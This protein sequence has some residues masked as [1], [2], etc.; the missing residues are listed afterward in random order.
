MKKYSFIARCVVFVYTFLYIGFAQTITSAGSADNVSD[1]TK[2]KYGFK[3]NPFIK[4]PKS[5]RPISLGQPSNI[6]REIIFDPETKQYIIREKI[7]SKLYRPPLYL[8]I[9]EFSKYEFNR[10]QKNYWEELAD[11]ELAEERRRRLFPVIEINSPTF[12]RI[13]GGNTIDISPRGSADVTLMGQY[14][15]NQNPMFNERQ[16]K[17]WGFDFDQ[18]INLNLT[19]RIGERVQVNANFNSQAQFGFENQ[20][21]FDYVAK[22]DDILRRL[23][24]GNVSMPLNSTLIQGSESLFGI[25]AQLQFGKLTFTGLL[26][27]QRSHQKE[28]TITNGSRDSE[29]V[30]EMDNYEANQHFFLGQYFRDTYNRSLAL[31][32][33]LNTQVNITQIE[34]WTSNRSNS[35][36]EARDIMALMDL[37]EYTPSNSL[38]SRASQPLPSTG[39]PGE[40]APS[41]SNNLLTLLGE[42]GRASNSNFTQS[43]FASTGA[44]DNY[45]KLTYARKLVE[46]RDFT[47]NR[48]LGYI[49][50]IY[51]LHQDQVL[52]V[53]Y[54]YLA[55]GREYQVG[56]FSTDIPVTPSEPKMLYTKLLKNETIK[57]NLPTWDLMM[58][59]VYSLGANNISNTNFHVQIYRTEDET[60]AQ[61]P[62]LYEGIN[63]VDKTWLQLT[64]LDRLDQ[65]QAAGADGLMDFLENIT[66]EPLRGKL[67]FPVVEPF[68]RD[69]AAQFTSGETQL[70]EKYT[71]PELYTMTQMDAQQKY[72]NKNRYLLKGRYS[73]A[74]GSAEYQLGAMN[75]RPNSVRVMSGGAVL[76]E[77]IDYN[78][79]YQIGNLRILNQA[80]LLSGQPIS[81]SMEDETLYGLQQKTLMGGRFDYALNPNIH[82]GATVMNLTEK[83]L[84]EKVTIGQEPISNTMLGAD[85]TY[86]APSRWLT[87]LVDK[88]PFLSTKEESHISFYGEFAQLLPGHPR[89]LNT[90]DN[91]TGTTYIDNFENSVSYIDIKGYLGWQISGT[92]R[93]FP[94]SNLNDDLSYGYNRSHLTFYNIDP[95]FYQPS[96]L[97][98]RLTP[99][100]LSD[101]RVR[102]VTEQEVFPFRNSRTGSDV[103]LSTLDMTYYPMLRGQYNYTTT[104]V[105]SDGTLSNPQNR[106]GGMFRKIDQTDFEAQNIEFL[107]MWMMDPTLTNPNKAGGDIYINLGNISEDIL[108]DGRKSLE[109]GLSPTGDKSQIEQ[110]VW[111]NVI[112]NQ[113]V[114]QAFENSNES[115]LLQDI[116]LDGL[117]N[118]EERSFHSNFLNQLQGILNPTAFASLQDDPSTDDY[119]YFRG[120]HFDQSVGI[121]ERYKRYNGTQG[122]TRTNDQSLADFG[123]ETSANTLLPDGEDVN[124]DNTMN[125][126]DE[127]YQYKLSIRPQ[128]M[129]VGQNFIVDEQTTQV[130]L[131]NSQKSDVKWY[132]IRIPLNE[133]ESRHGDI[134]DF[135]SVR[136]VRMFMTNFADT[137][138][139]R[140]GRLQ[141]VRGDWR[142]YNSENVA[143]KVISD[144]AMGVVASDNSIFN[145]ANVSI[146]ENGKREP[147]PYKVPPGINRQIDWS[148]N[149]LD[150]ELNEQ[151][152]SLDVKNLRDGYGRATYKTASHDFRPYGRLEMFI[153]AEGENLNNGDFR[154][155]VRL[156]TD[157][158]YNYYEYDMPLVITPYG[159]SSA[160][161]IWPMENRMNIK[162]NLLKDAK[163][164]REKAVLNGQPWPLDVPF[165]YADGENRIT[166]IGTPDL[167]KVR[168]YMM[169]VR[170]PLRGSST[171]NNLD[172]GR[173][174]HGEFWFNELRLTDFDDKGGWAATARLNLKLADFAN[175]SISG[176][177]STVGFGS[178]Y[179]RVGER[180]RSE[181]TYFD[182][183]TNAELGKFFHPRH[184]IVIPFYF[185]YSNQ[186]STP[187]YNPLNPDIELN[188]ALATMSN[189]SRD[190][191]LRLVQD[192][193][194]RKSFS[195]TNI[196]KI[197]TNNES[198]IRPWSIENFGLSYAYAEYNHRDYNTATSIQRNYR[199]AL[200][201]NYSNPTLN[202][203]EPFK[204]IK[205]KNLAFIKD[206]NFNLM[207][208][209]LNFRLEVNRIYN[210]NTLRD[211]SSNNLLPT[212][213]N[214]NFNM[215]RI[216]GISWDLTKSLR[217]DFNATNYS[218]IDEPAGR[219]DGI[220]QDT[221][222]SNFWKMGRTTDYNHMM[223]LTYTLPINKI[224]YLEWISVIT[225]YGTQFNW[226]SEP[227]I[228]FQS[229][230][231]SLGNSIQ[232]N[233]T[234][235]VNPTLSF[236]TLYNKFGFIR[237]NSGRNA[238]GSKAF[239]VQLLTSVRNVGG[240]YTRIEGTYLP[241]YTPNTNLLGYNF[242]ANAPGWEFLFGSQRDILSRAVTNGWI[243]SDTLQT[244][245]YTKTFAENISVIAN[246]EP[247]KG[248]RIDLTATRVDNYNFSST[249]ELEYNPQSGTL[250]PITPY[251]TGNYS[252]SQIA[253][254]TSFTSH[255]ELFKKFEEQR[256]IIS[257]R[258]SER[259][260]NSVKGDPESFADGYSKEQQDVVINSFLSTYLGK[261]PDQSS[262]DRKPRFPIPNWRISYNGL[263]NIVALQDLFTS[264]N[265]SHAYQSQYV[266]AGYNSVIRYTETD[267]AP[268]ERDINDNFLPKNLYGQVSIIDRFVPLI[269]VDVR[270]KNNMS[271]NAEYRKSRD[272]NFSLQN[273]Q[274]AMMSEESLIFGMGYRKNNVQ[275]P[276]GLFA[277]R[278]WK[279]DFNFKLDFALNDRKTVVYRSDI[280]EAEVSGGNRSISINPTLEYTVNQFYN[281]RLFYNSNS[282]KPYTS[283]NYAT[284]YTYFGI[285]L[286]VLFQ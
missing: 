52:A 177:R 179:Q 270:L 231:I 151:A 217:L 275:L 123:V 9:D 205:N 48:R 111:G 155:F 78:I 114:I 164:A 126:V 263:S 176:T 35:F 94:E 229:D 41:I 182:I 57:T 51:P 142:K 68:G 58:K 278:K 274:M 191:L 269:G 224:P 21:R 268:S 230:Q 99:N 199:G 175:V 265:L 110:T 13:F 46:G 104:G 249:T 143:D 120:N 186:K 88:L 266:I 212:Y 149:N 53:A 7:G 14:N 107:E 42:S 168:F 256:L 236:S 245:L 27:Q 153:H 36:E 129:V 34:V 65:Q 213:Y 45:V 267:G 254:H 260:I 98:P 63:T 183:T 4:L 154:A 280:N 117:T 165:E 147:I 100:M 33:I 131:A 44:N 90:A 85:F 92:P 137:S 238:K 146:E 39:I 173:D 8:S 79:D 261:D 105:N 257:N 214:K 144:Y 93:M 28:F 243:S 252:I 150:V 80:L 201:Y 207:P 102:K 37:G 1:S 38:I 241:G 209:L 262:I 166:V 185:N 59:N 135:K 116:G 47:V 15:T 276:F 157:D 115:R 277:D 187:E 32:P 232:N 106:W 163:L 22:D 84:T 91:N 128:D 158:K 171:S 73:S 172:D 148:N 83:P 159:T 60:G 61:R 226:Q 75:L 184:G 66:I 198:L 251:R 108:K 188:S 118:V 67:I 139:V 145:V 24:I 49:S 71:F 169:G 233:R 31:A 255:N 54:K 17:Q 26:S 141:F 196:R 130:T 136:F 189:N 127:Y 235:Q 222:W 194:M 240:A 203:Y 234:I 133:F 181:D 244:N 18:N 178:I 125:E 210:E 2:L 197:K 113:P 50:L 10:L 211:N 56:E 20:V 23:E 124:R 82:I 132:K 242:D 87:R 43:F 218:I 284:S 195:F 97:N 170:N 204:G 247:L 70:V 77:G 19:G 161:L 279:N 282:V 286:R 192:Y 216:Y 119:T 40:P 215:N 271:A 264:I 86:N 134:Q 16:R 55:N 190:S 174:L 237:Q 11:K 227:L 101:H 76:E 208:S 285:N 248:L 156:G 281:I 258:L 219:I 140:F 250:E 193:T 12:E 273:S 272:M 246:L 138:V 89:G 62:A 160:D 121:L 112:K 103:Y 253:I 74:G 6:E 202:F 5:Y 167:S 228:A 122:N 221:M 109:N 64:G 220:K 206:L 30:L 259:N 180:N 81:I 69:L 96:D 3:D 239:F 162:I 25:K 29:F 225:R 283:Q 72:P 200:D 95:I 223:N 152:L